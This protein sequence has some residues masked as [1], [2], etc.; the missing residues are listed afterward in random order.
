MTTNSYS[1]SVTITVSGTGVA[2]QTQQSDAFYIFT[3][4]A[5][6]PITPYHAHCWVMDING[7]PTETFGQIPQYNSSHSYQFIMTAPGGPLTFI[8]CDGNHT[9]NSGSLN[10]TVSANGSSSSAAQVSSISNIQIGASFTDML[11][12][13]NKKFA[14]SVT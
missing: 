12:E 13:E 14:R 3:D 11:S 6:N 9:D 8:I 10:I 2:D 1:G 7:Q 5:G 4:N